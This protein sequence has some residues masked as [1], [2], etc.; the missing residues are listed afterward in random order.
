AIYDT[1]FTYRRNDLNHPIP[2]LV[3]AWTSS[4]AKT[5]TFRLKRNVRFADGTPLTAADVVFSLSRLV[6]LP[7]NPSLLLSGVAVS[8]ARADTGVLRSTK[9]AAQLPSV[10]ANPATGIVNSKLVRSHEG[11]DAADADRA[12]KAERWFNSPASQGAGSGPYELQSYN[13]T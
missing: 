3:Q 12:D 11:T 1:L 10:L 9:P 4:D 7:G 6:N 5:F 2:L 13:V 8:A